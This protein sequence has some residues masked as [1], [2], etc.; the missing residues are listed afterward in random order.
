MAHKTITISEEAYQSL[1]K[2]KS[3]NESFTEA[4]LRL[5]SGRGDARSLLEFLEVIPPS[6]DLADHVEKAMKRMRSTKVRRATL[7]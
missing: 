1:A 4:I 7:E 3:P 2:H 6:E 5:T